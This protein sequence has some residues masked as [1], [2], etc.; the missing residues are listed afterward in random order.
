MARFYPDQRWWWLAISLLA[1]PVHSDTALDNEAEASIFGYAKTMYIADDKKG[2]RPNQSTPGFGGKLGGQTASYQ[3]F[4][5]KGAWYL[6]TD[7][8]LRRSNP[9]ETDGYMFDVDKKPYSL[10]GEAQVNYASGKTRLTLGRQEINSPL[11]ASY[12]Y[13]IIPNLFEAYTLTN[14]DI[15]DTTLTLSYVSKMSGLDGLVSFSEFHSM[16]QQAYTSLLVTANGTIDARNGDTLDP[17]RVVGHRGVWMTGITYEKEHQ[18]QLWNYYGVDTLNTLYLEG[19]LKKPLNDA[20]TAIFDGQTYRV[21]AVGRFKEYLAEHGLNAN[22]QLYGVKGTLAHQPSGLSLALALTKF[23]GD[24]HTV[25]AHG[26]WGGYPEFVNMPYLYAEKDNVSAI[27]R[28]HMS[29]ASALLDLGA[30]GFKDHSLL[31]GHARIN[32]NQSILA[33][34]DIRVNTII[35]RAKLSPTLSTRIALEARN[36]GNA[37]YDN[38]FVAMGLRYDF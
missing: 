11:I 29:K 34:S 25:T 17:S 37:R 20:V 15:A 18:L 19:R 23:T 27:A 6:T 22:Y 35:Y 9:R 7:L 31:F 28:S 36:S 32:L 10:L 2:G 4:S 8:G 14:Q 24:E 30:Y 12:D 1:T 26:N 38:G 5:L 13:R 3:G 33:N 16:S 21:G